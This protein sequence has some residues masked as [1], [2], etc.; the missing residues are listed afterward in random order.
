MSLLEKINSDLKEALTSKKE[1]EVLVLRGLIA[2]VK[3]KEIELRSS[4]KELS[5]EDVMNVVKKEAKKRKDAIELY[6][7]GDRAE[8][9]EKEEVELK[10]L[11][12]FLPEQLSD[13]DLDKAVEDVIN[14]LGDDLDF[15]LVMKEVMKK[16]GSG[17][18]GSRVSKIVKEKLG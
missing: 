13:D 14:S 3:N 5:E 16:I 17:A 9:A 11:E 10:I 1:V 6:K 7:Q 12:D 8:L 2:E 15:G 18:D 4:D